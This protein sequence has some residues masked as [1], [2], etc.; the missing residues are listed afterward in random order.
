MSQPEITRHDQATHFWCPQLGQ[1]MAF[2]YCRRA[3]NGLPCAKVRECF[4][5]H[6]DVDEFLAAHYSQEELDRCLGSQPS[7]L[8]RIAAALAGA[9]AGGQEPS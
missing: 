2:A 7:R 5:S 4:Q 9:K 6:F 1:T 3:Q 8:E